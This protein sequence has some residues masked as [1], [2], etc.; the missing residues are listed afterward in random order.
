MKSWAL[1]FCLLSIV[2][3]RDSGDYIREM[4]GIREIIMRNGPVI[5]KV[6]ASGVELTLRYLCRPSLRRESEH[7]IWEDILNAFEK[8]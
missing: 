6:E 5:T 3:P 1:F 2:D 8:R 4:Q 7:N